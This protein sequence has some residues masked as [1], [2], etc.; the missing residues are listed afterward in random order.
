M[1]SEPVG[2]SSSTIEDVNEEERRRRAR[3]NLAGSATKFSKKVLES[4]A[5]KDRIS[6]AVLGNGV[7]WSRAAC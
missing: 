7:H 4:H 2:E 6:K 5:G 3:V 1:T